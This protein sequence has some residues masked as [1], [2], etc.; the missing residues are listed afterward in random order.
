MDYKKLLTKARK[1][2]PES[3]LVKERFEIPKIKGH[4]EGNKTILINF[5]QIA[6]TFRRNSA[7]L[8]KFLSKELATPIT[9]KGAQVILGSKVSASL[10]NEKISKYAKEF[11]LCFECGK[12]DTKIVVENNITYLRCL[13]CGA[14]YPIKS[15]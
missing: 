8:I 9:K 6:D 15:L 14:K 13:A 12:P 7:H 3:V 1:E 11:V 5:F 4:I 2:L 10:I